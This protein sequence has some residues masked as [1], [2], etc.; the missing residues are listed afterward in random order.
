MGMLIDGRWETDDRRPT[1]DG[2]FE[3]PQSAFRSGVGSGTDFPVEAGRYH[4]FVSPTCPW[5]HRTLIFRVLKG[6]EDVVGVTLLAPANT[7]HGW[8][9]DP[10][11]DPL[12]GA[13]Y[14]YQLYQRADPAY[15]G[16]VTVPVLW[17]IDTATIVNN[18]SAEIIRLVNSAFDAVAGHPERDYYPA[19]L[20][21]EIDAVN[22]RV[23]HGLNNG[24]YRAGF[25]QTQAAYE[26]AAR[27]VLETLDWLEARLG[28]ARY[29]A[30]DVL[31]EADWR[32]FPTLI[33]YDA[34]Y[35]HL[36]K[37]NFHR[38]ADYPALHAYTRELYQH[39][40]IAGT[41]DL[42]AVR[43]GYYQ[44]M[45]HLNPYGIVPMGPHGDVLDFSRP[46][47]RR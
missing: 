38:L 28:D 12:T 20:R 36:F 37:C 46:H 44:G 39:P 11:P 4:L 32:A 33:R 35:H 16:R 31:T 22:E 7:E 27:G 26:E 10:A 25:A 43:K 19:A 24:V 6:L 8:I 41:V 17:D 5:A 15:T 42:Q 13:T 23:Y 2:R 30:G 40:G 3:R 18:E 21:D 1:P 29:L 45:T 34:V 9:F 47:G 14:L